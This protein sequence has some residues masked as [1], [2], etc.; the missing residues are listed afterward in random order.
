LP[1]DGP[2]SN[3]STAPTPAQLTPVEIPAPP[4][5][6]PF[7][8]IIEDDKAFSDALGQ[9]IRDQGLQYLVAPNG[10]T[11]LRL[12]RQ[13]K[14]CGIILDVKLPDQSGFVIMEQLRST[15]ET[16]SIPVHFFSSVEDVQRGMAMGAVGYLTK[17]AS[18]SQLAEMIRT[19]APKS[20][21]NMRRILVV[22]DDLLTGESLVN[23]I[24]A[25]KIQ[26]IRVTN[27]RAALAALEKERFSCMIVDLSLPDM[28][29]LTLLDTIQTKFGEEMAPVIVYTARSLSKTEAKRLEAYAEAVIL[30]EGPSAERLRNELRLFV[31][32]LKEGFSKRNR[33]QQPTAKVDLEGKNILLVDDDMR[34]VYALSAVLRAK[35]VSVTIADN[36]L[37]AIDA[38]KQDP[39]IDA[40]LMD[41]MMPEMDGFEAMRRIRKLPGFAKIPIIALTAKA[42]KSDEQD[43]FKA[44]A[45]AYLAKPIDADRLLNKLNEL[46]SGS[47]LSQ[48]KGY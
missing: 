40:V 15:A 10:E 30:K 14:P 46:L 23:Q 6:V 35:G 1:Y 7:I 39:H 43:A 20:N 37:A 48:M 18:R 22:E 11:G 19:L 44:G 26:A 4:P 5:G 27:A 31:R 32:R 13:H 16:A 3:K 24:A 17:P 28:D 8:L 38:L 33:L 47:T 25:E 41:I 45:T 34:T 2:K 12:A 9:I 21:L 29:G 42:M 36:G